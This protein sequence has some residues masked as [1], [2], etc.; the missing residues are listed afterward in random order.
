MSAKAQAFRQQVTE[1]IRELETVA[2]PKGVE[3][4]LLEVRERA[5][6]NRAQRLNVTRSEAFLVSPEIARF[7]SKNQS[8]GEAESIAEMRKWELGQGLY[9]GSVVFYDY[10]HEKGYYDKT[11]GARPK[12][13]LRDALVGAEEIEVEV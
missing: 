7:R 3:T 11:G 2:I 5:D 1:E 6:R 13:M 4:I 9:L 12:W 10:F 8:A